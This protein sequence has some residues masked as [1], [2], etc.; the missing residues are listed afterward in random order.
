MSQMKNKMNI[1]LVIGLLFSFLNVFSQIPEF[2]AKTDGVLIPR[3]DRTTVSS[4]SNGQLVYDIN[5]NSFW[6]YQVNQW[7]ELGAS[8]PGTTLIDSDGDTEIH[9]ELY[10]DVDYINFLING[11]DKYRMRVNAN[12]I[13]RIG[14][15]NS[16]FNTCM[17]QE[18]GQSITTAEGNTFYGY[19]TGRSLTSGHRN[20][21]IGEKAGHNLSTGFG[22]VLVGRN[23]GHNV[24]LGSNN[25][26]LGNSSGDSVGSNSVC[27]GAY[28]GFLSYTSN[29]V[30]VG[31]YAGNNNTHG[32]QTF[33]GFEAGLNC[34]GEQTTAIGYQA[35]GDSNIGPSNTLL[36]Y[37]TGNSLTTGHSNTLL[38]DQSGLGILDGIR[39]VAIGKN[40]LLTNTSG[41]FNV[42]VGVFSLDANTSGSSNTA[43]GYLSLHANETGTRNSAFGISSMNANTT[44]NDN[45]SIGYLSLLQN[46]SGQNN[47]AIGSS[48]GAKITGNNNTALGT[49][50]NSAVDD[51]NN[52]TGVGYNANPYQSDQVM[53]GDGLV[54]SIGGTVGWSLLSDKRFKNNV[55]ENVPGLEFINLLTPITYTFDLNEYEAHFEREFNY[56]RK[57]NHHSNPQ[58]SNLIRSGFLAQ[59]V[60]EAANKIGYEFS[61]V[62]KPA[63]ESG[64]YALRYAEFTVPLV[65]AVQELNDLC[66]QLRKENKDLKQRLEKIETLLQN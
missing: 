13:P 55:T 31:H 35:G 29:S 28:S 45:T 19:K 30:S 66:D 53:V 64:I 3:L 41:S 49:A 47:T 22:N 9:T 17:G 51:I 60:E 15:Y 57:Q 34:G 8:A 38:G 43:V 12:L 54:T 63:N 18:S 2:E 32:N 25:V 37:K 61:G 56:K 26:Y 21:V 33:V 24:N 20:T 46:I 62:D 59:D 23:A 7:K 44:G 6:Y 52:T 1:G 36:G 48:S 58:A 40:T 4:P 11:N 10:P 5:T 42:A 65:K 27:V 39:N 16:N 50:A 14:V